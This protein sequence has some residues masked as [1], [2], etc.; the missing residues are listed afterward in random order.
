MQI[1]NTVK[2]NFDQ[3]FQVSLAPFAPTRGAQGRPTP[4]Y[5]RG[6]ASLLLLCGIVTL[7]TTTARW[8]TVQFKP[9]R[10]SGKSVSWHKAHRCWCERSFVQ[11]PVRRSD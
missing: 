9:E 11:F 5:H 10:E 3:N 7:G 2:L 8:T 1:V 6:T 4:T